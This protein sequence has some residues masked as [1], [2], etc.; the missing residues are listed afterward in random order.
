MMTHLQAVNNPGGNL[1]QV[2]NLESFRNNLANHG[3]DL[4]RE[5]C[6][7]LQVNVGQ[8][9]NQ[10]CRHCHL[11]A[12]PFRK[13]IMNEE[14]V[15]E[16][17]KLAGSFRFETIDITGGAPEMNPYITTLVSRLAPLT[18]TLI[19]RSNLTAI[20]AE[21]QNGLLGLLAGNRV[22]ITAS[23]PSLNEAQSE[24]QRGENTFA[25]SIRTLRKLNALGYG[26]PDSGL[27]LN[28]VSNP[29]G[30]FLPSSQEQ[31]EKRFRQMLA[32][33]WDILFN[34]LYVFANVPLG[35]FL[36][37]LEDSGNLES[38]ILKLAA[39]FNPCTL[40]GL[41]CRSLVS[42]SWDGYLFDCDFNQSLQLHMGSR[43]KH[44]SELQDLPG[45][46]DTIA[47]SEHCYTCTAGS[48]FT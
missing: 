25:P 34:N 20:A 24:A 12:G 32:H 39:H 6:N 5:K 1:Y 28:L 36:T 41:M 21:K 17:I 22:T 7:T 44:V 27:E 29:T 4:T 23:L 14:T 10:S 2:P 16:V 38:Y 42:V 30:A 18:N 46:G 31:V 43:K 11:D 48:G 9:C 13:E 8:L 15:S 45:P 35:R 47:V 26:H 33:K 19:V 40:D 37:W 3:I